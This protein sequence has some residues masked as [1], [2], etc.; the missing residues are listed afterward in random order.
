M[1]RL[2][3]RASPAPQSRSRG[4][5]I[6]ALFKPN[7][8]K[9]MTTPVPAYALGDALY[10]RGWMVP[11]NGAGTWWHNGS[12]PGTT[13][14]IVRTPTGMC[15]AALHAPSARRLQGAKLRPQAPG[16]PFRSASLPIHI[17]EMEMMSKIWL[18]LASYRGGA[19]PANRPLGEVPRRYLSDTDSHPRLTTI[20]RLQ[21]TRCRR[22][23][24]L[25]AKTLPTTRV[26]GIV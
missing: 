11:N 22:P 7:T 8:T 1:D 3:H 14:I 6:P 4:P 2:L 25:N 9:M 21:R 16:L 23:A 17:S 24:F 10:A 15:W 20:Y 18:S 12:L 19:S 5:G 26:P 13:S